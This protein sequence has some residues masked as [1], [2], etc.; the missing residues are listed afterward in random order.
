MW[1]SAIAFSL[2]VLVGIALTLGVRA[3][4][5]ASGWS[6]ARTADANCTAIPSRSAAAWRS[7]SPRCWCSARW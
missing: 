6:I 7:S 4:A 3:G 1:L 2:S 5:R